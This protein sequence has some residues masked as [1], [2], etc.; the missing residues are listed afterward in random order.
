MSIG[1]FPSL[2]LEPA[3]PL[4]RLQT[5]LPP[6]A[7]NRASAKEPTSRFAK[8]VQV[9]VESKPT[10]SYDRSLQS[11]VQEREGEKPCAGENTHAWPAYGVPLRWISPIHRAAPARIFSG[12][13][14][15][16]IGY[17]SC[18]GRK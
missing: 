4:P 15:R 7:Y 18:P 10:C 11:D 5:V 1:R 13:F 6:R 9:F 3:D 17:V 2:P 16:K 8:L 14:C 12:I